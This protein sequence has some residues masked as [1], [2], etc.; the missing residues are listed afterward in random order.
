MITVGVAAFA[1]LIPIT[2]PIGGLAAFAAL[3]EGREKKDVDHQA[4]QTGLYVG[5][6][7]V[8]S[9]VAGDLVLRALGISLPSLQIAGGLVVAHSGFGMIAPKPG[10]SRREADHAVT[11]ESVAF[12]PMALPLVA[13]P[14]AIG[15][16]IA[17]AARHTGIESRLGLVVGCVALA[18][19][20]GGVLRFGTPLIER[21][22]A[23][24]I[25]ALT[26][27]MGFLILA[28]GVELVSHGVL[29]LT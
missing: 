24:G 25:G 19:G 4:W 8:V 7:L 18:A 20:V 13:G 12:S 6:I 2:N 16:V 11:K 27:V 14:G 3:T 28:I 5:A 22:G 17:L 21:L 23:S 1:A 29:A 10:I 26:R 9:A 15:V